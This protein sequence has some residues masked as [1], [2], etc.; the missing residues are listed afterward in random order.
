MRD[1]KKIVFPGQNTP[2]APH[3]I[4]TDVNEQQGA[5]VCG[6]STIARQFVLRQ[7]QRLLATHRQ[8]LS[9]QLSSQNTTSLQ[10]LPVGRGNTLEG[11]SLVF[12]GERANPKGPSQAHELPVIDDVMQRLQTMVR[13]TLGTLPAPSAEAGVTR[14]QQQLLLLQQMRQHH[15]EMQRL[16]INT[17]SSAEMQS[18]GVPPEIGKVAMN[19]DKWRR[20]AVATPAGA[21][22]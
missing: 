1:T 2:P 19:V 20:T 7:C 16:V 10:S 13:D 9:D 12:P 11:P 4:Q 14:Y 18:S 3:V 22:G 17:A 5:P 6:T 21:S 8:Q 15:L